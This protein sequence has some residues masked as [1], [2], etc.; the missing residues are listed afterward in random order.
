MADTPDDDVLAGLPALDSVEHAKANMAVVQRLILQ[1]Y[2]KQGAAAVRAAEVWLKLEEHDELRQKLRLLEKANKRLQAALTRIEV[3]WPDAALAAG[4]SH[5]QGRHGT[6]LAQSCAARTATAGQ[7]PEA[8]LAPVVLTRL[9]N[10]TGLRTY[11]ARSS[12]SAL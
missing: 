1:G 11:S 6:T 2:V 9:G 10:C 5:G 3:A 4:G 12:S 8:R 7:W